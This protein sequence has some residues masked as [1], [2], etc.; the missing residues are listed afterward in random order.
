VLSFTRGAQQDE[1]LVAVPRLTV[2]LDG[3]WDDT[4][5]DLPDGRWHNV[6]TD[7]PW[8]GRVGA[9][10]LFARFPVALCERCD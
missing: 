7:E 1:L 4:S 3:D 2:Q 6:L 9:A 5:I 8:K 10:S